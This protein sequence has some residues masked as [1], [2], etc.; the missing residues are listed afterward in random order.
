MKEREREMKRKERKDAEK[1]ARLEEKLRQLEAGKKEES[2][3]KTDD[4]VDM[5]KI[6]AVGGMNRAQEETHRKFVRNKKKT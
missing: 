5:I 6:D 2:D 1:I 3:Y 4:D